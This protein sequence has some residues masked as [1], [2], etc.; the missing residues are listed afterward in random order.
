MASYEI[1]RLLFDRRFVE[2]RITTWSEKLGQLALVHAY[3]RSLRCR[4]LIGVRAWPVMLR[5]LDQYAVS[6]TCEPSETAGAETQ[7]EL[8]VGATVAL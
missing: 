5:G 1:A 4:L 7:I 8:L 6:Q 3:M 2:N